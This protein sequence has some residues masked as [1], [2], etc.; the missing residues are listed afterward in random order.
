MHF[1]AETAREFLEDGVTVQ[2]VCTNFAVCNH[3]TNLPMPTLIQRIG[4]DAD[5]GLAM[6]VLAQHFVCSKCGARNPHVRR[7]RIGPSPR[8]SEV[9]G[10][11]HQSAEVPFAEATARSV[12]LHRKAEAADSARP[13]GKGRWRKFGRR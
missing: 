11:T 1:H 6:P 2:A 8:A 10:G 12:A 9:P 4:W 3:W 5:M 13:K 7:V